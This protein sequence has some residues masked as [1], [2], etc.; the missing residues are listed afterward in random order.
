MQIRTELEIVAWVSCSYL[1]VRVLAFLLKRW[2]RA[3]AAIFSLVSIGAA[4]AAY[5]LNQ[6]RFDVAILVVCGLLA[7]TLECWVR[8]WRESTKTKWVRAE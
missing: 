2:P 1:F 8:V 4:F 3:I 7:G 5:N 6:E